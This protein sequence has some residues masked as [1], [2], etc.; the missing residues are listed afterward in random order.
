LTWVIPAGSVGLDLTWIEI[1]RPFIPLYAILLFWGGLA[2]LL[3]FF[4]PSARAASMTT[5]SLLVGNFLL[6]G[7]ANANE[8]LK[9]VTEYLPLHFFQSGGAIT[10]INVNWLIGLL[11]SALAFAILAWLRFKRR[12]IRV[13]GEGGWS[14]SLLRRRTA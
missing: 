7:L 1:L 13:G 11:A 4:L 2:L 12:D 3:S 5:A 8:D 9:A 6:D 10:E 14:L